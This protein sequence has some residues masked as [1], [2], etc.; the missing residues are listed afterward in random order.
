MKDARAAAVWLQT[1]AHAFYSVTLC[2][3]VSVGSEEG[4]EDVLKLD[5]S[6]PGYATRVG[7]RHL[8]GE[9]MAT[10]LVAM[11]VG[12]GLA[13]GARTKDGSE[14][15]RESCLAMRCRGS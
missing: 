15:A 6:C 7:G 12:G 3:N 11:A 13:A 2:G 4:G 9:R 1:K 8:A 10:E 5:G 14:V